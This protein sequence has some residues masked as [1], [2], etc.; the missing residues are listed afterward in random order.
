MPG[1]HYQFSFE[2]SEYSISPQILIILT[3]QFSFLFHFH[4]SQTSFLTIFSL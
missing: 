1:A 4:K 2:T 3:C